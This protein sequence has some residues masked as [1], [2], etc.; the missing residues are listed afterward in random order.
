MLTCLSE[1]T[2]CSNYVL[3]GGKLSLFFEARKLQGLTYI[4]VHALCFMYVAACFF[5]L[6]A[7]LQRLHSSTE[8][9]YV[10]TI[11]SLVCWHY[12]P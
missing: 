11:N 8:V 4:T 7:E 5:V 3:A 10:G 2:A 6:S 12:Q 1:D 9:W